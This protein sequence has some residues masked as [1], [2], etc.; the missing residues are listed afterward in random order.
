MRGEAEPEAATTFARPITSQ[1]SNYTN[2]VMTSA[3]N[4]TLDPITIHSLDKKKNNNTEKLKRCN[5]KR[6]CNEMRYDQRG[7]FPKF[8][9]QKNATRCKNENCAARTH[10]YCVKCNVH[11]CIAKNKDCFND[12]HVLVL[13]EI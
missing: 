10:M 7:H 2:L 11:L 13:P 1:S 3:A 5:E 8:D 4:L 12:F 9:E 6:P